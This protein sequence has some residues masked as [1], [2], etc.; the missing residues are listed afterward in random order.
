MPSSNRNRERENQ[1]QK[2][3]SNYLFLHNNF[4]LNF[5]MLSI[6]RYYLTK[7]TWKLS[8]V[9][10]MSTNLSVCLTIHSHLFSMSIAIRLKNQKLSQN[11]LTMKKRVKILNKYFADKSSFVCIIGNDASKLSVTLNCFGFYCIFVLYSGNTITTVKHLL[12]MNW[13]ITFSRFIHHF[14][15][16]TK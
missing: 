3:M 4:R 13:R 1:I 9:H 16:S 6:S 14:P 7:W 10:T 2:K 12:M 5:E 8:L 15:H 11:K